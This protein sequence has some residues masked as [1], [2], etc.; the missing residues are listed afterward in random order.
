MLNLRMYISQILA[1]LSLYPLFANYEA[2]L[3]TVFSRENSVKSTSEL[4]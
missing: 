1:K 4:K 3:T 2:H